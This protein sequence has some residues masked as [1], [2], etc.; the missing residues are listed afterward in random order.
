MGAAD[1]VE[2]DVQS[3]LRSLSR[4]GVKPGLERIRGLLERLGEPQRAFPCVHVGG[5]NAKGSISAITASILRASSYRVG[6]YTSPHLVRYHERIQV[7]GV[8][9]ADAALQAIFQEVAEAAAEVKAELGADPTEFEV[10]TAAAFLHFAR[11]GVEIAVVEV[12][13]GGRLD[14]TNVVDSRVVALGPISLDHTA[15]LGPDIPSIAH[16]K[17]GIFRRGIPVV[18]SPQRPEAAAVIR[19]RAA[20]CGGSLIWVQEGP[21]T[22]PAPEAPGVEERATF[23]VRNWGAEG[24]TVDVRTPWRDYESL[25]VPLLGRHQLQNAAVAVTVAET[26]RQQGMAVSPEDVRLGV[27]ATRW[28]GRLER[29]LGSP[30]LLLDGVHNPDGAA[31][32]ARSLREI[33]RDR[34]V[35][36][37]MAVMG[38]KDLEAVLAPLIPFAAGLIATR[39]ASSRTAPSD[40]DALVRIA[41]SHGLP[42]RSIEGVAAAMDEACREAGPDGL[43]CVCGSLYLVG[44]VKGLLESGWTPDARKVTARRMP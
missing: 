13:M 34:R 8:E 26:L 41:E 44:E 39:P 33:L 29:V 20:A 22:P 10:G 9:I 38:E 18:S 30:T 35:T 21:D 1:S 16:E 31:A 28:P 24:G 23:R 42:A 4:F 15:V 36:F 19:E 40:P 37:V 3:Y 25:H 2:F 12:G 6:L 32:L 7:D 5:T 14:S 11:L 17:A 43:V 27:A